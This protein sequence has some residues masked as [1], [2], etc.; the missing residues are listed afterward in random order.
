MNQT[1]QTVAQAFTANQTITNVF[2]GLR[3]AELP[4]K[5]GSR[6]KVTLAASVDNA[7]MS[8]Q[9]YAGNRAQPVHSS[10]VSVASA[11]G[12]IVTRDDVVCTFVA[13]AGEK[14]QLEATDTSGAANDALFR[15]IV[16]PI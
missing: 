1:V 12:R 6:F 3:L 9:L 5:F 11:A 13:D 2:S 15:L 14:L 7:G 8:I 16:Q 10:E 4:A